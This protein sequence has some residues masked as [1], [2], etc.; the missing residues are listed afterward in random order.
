M[1]LLIEVQA[2]VITEVSL[3]YPSLDL[4]VNLLDFLFN[5]LKLSHSSAN[6]ANVKPFLCKLSAIFSPDSITSSGDNTPPLLP[7]IPLNK[8]MLLPEPILPDQVTCINNLY[9][10]FKQANVIN[11]VPEYPK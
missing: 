2:N 1:N 7:S 5:F 8:V 6:Q 9:D 4:V 3:N 11:D 10:D